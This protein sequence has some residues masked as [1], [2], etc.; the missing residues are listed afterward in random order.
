MTG[1]KLSSGQENR[2]ATTF[3]TQ[4]PCRLYHR[5]VAYYLPKR[6]IPNPKQIQITGIQN[7]GLKRG[8]I[9]KSQ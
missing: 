1:I 2:T 8:Q 9:G 6:E 4:N 5:Y 3:T 7:L